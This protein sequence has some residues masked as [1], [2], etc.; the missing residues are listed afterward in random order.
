MTQWLSALP[1]ESTRPSVSSQSP[2]A[3]PPLVALAGAFCQ[4]PAARSVGVT[5]ATLSPQA[6]EIQKRERE[7]RA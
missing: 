4:V 7:G 5:A 1:C 3:G 2:N 6:S